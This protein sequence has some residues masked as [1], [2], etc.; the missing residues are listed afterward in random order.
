MSKIAEML[1]PTR[2]AALQDIVKASTDPPAQ[3]TPG[4]TTYRPEAPV[5]AEVTVINGVEYD[6]RSEGFVDTACADCET[7]LKVEVAPRGADL[8]ALVSRPR[9]SV[10][11]DCG[12]ARVKG[13]RGVLVYDARPTNQKETPMPEIDLTKFSEAEL[14]ALAVQARRR[15]VAEAAEALPAKRE[16]AKKAEAER[17]AKDAALKAE[18]RA[19]NKRKAWM[20]EFQLHVFVPALDFTE[21]DL[22]EVVPATVRSPYNKAL[23]AAG[24]PILDRETTTYRM[25]RKV[26]KRLWKQAEV[27]VEAPKVKAEPKAE[28]E[29]DRLVALLDPQAQAKVEAYAKVSGMNAEQ[30]R[31]HLASLNL[32]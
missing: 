28:P 5:D 19:K 22:D 20:G 26:H 1:D 21:V 3:E 14:A 7:P 11:L 13:Q 24:E 31:E 12:D 4:E 25:L 32:I 2:V 10:C 23:H 17:Q 30:A 9:I 18:D 15:M 27:A 29:G 6:L 8:E 16:E